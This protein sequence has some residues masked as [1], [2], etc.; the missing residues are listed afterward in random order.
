MADGRTERRELYGVEA[1]AARARD[2]HTVNLVCPAAARRNPIHFFLSSVLS[3]LR[4]AVLLESRFYA[5]LVAGARAMPSDLISPNR[6]SLKANHSALSLLVL[7]SI[8]ISFSDYH[9]L[10]FL[11]I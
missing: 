2:A 3:P 8:R 9:I 1:E 5:R 4:R 7:S 6:E 11:L 10:R